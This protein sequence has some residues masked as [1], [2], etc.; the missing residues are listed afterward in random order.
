MARS[1]SRADH[2]RLYRIEAF[3]YSIPK[4]LPN[5]LCDI[6]AEH[7]SDP[8]PISSTI[9]TCAASFQRSHADTW[10]Q[11]KL[12][13][14]EDQLSN[15]SF[16]ISGTS[17]CEHG[18]LDVVIRRRELTLVW[19]TRDRCVKGK[20]VR[21]PSLS[22]CHLLPQCITYHGPLL[23]ST[24]STSPACHLEQSSHVWN[25][26]GSDE[27]AIDV[28]AACAKRRYEADGL[29][30]AWHFIPAASLEK[31]SG[32]VIVLVCGGGGMCGGCE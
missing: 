13:F 28:P 19:I 20:I 18:S 16:V 24:C 11:D 21:E 30:L 8:T 27:T 15:L 25:D 4:F 7:A 2:A 23:C 10:H 5:L 22:L 1:T 32:I 12:K 9:R 31:E 26:I 29:A 3:P 6:L 17:Y 14:T